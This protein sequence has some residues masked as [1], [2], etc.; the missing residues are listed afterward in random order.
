VALTDCGTGHPD[1]S[2]DVGDDDASYDG[3]PSQEDLTKASYS[4]DY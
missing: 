3:A 4:A 2:S 1:A